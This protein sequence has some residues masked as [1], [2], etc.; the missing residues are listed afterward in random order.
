MKKVKVKV[1]YLNDQICD[2]YLIEDSKDLEEYSRFTKNVVGDC[3]RKT[4]KSKT[5]ISRFDHTIP[6]KGAASGIMSLANIRAKYSKGIPDGNK[7]EYSIWN[8]PLYQLGGA[9][10]SK[11]NTIKKVLQEG[12]VLIGIEMGGITPFMEDQME[13]LETKDVVLKEWGSEPIKI[14]KEAKWLVLE[15]DVCLSSSIE[16]Y[17]KS[18]DRQFGRILSLK[19]LEEDYLRDHII[20]FA[21]R[22]GEVIFFSTTGLDLQQIEIGFEGLSTIKEL[23]V[24]IHISGN[25]SKEFLSLLDKFSNKIDITMISDDQLCE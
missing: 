14:P 15:N 23:K 17:V 8:N 20:N 3:I 19:S 10:Q 21:I 4:I 9:G 16:Q 22:G 13:I 1:K 11:I 25:P 5:P 7:E 2:Y 18:K 6:S 12:K 24:L